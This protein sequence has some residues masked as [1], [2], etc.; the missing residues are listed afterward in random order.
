MASWSDVPEE[1][2]RVILEE[3]GPLERFVC[4]SVSRRLRALCPPPRTPSSSSPSSYSTPFYCP[5]FIYL[6]LVGGVIAVE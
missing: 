6:F 3:L 5:I 2:Q 1:V 4:A